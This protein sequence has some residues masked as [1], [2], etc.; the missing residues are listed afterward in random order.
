M[1]EGYI[2]LYRGI[3]DND[4]WLQEPF[5]K[6]Q[7]WIDILL[8][9]N[10]T[11]GSILLKNGEIVQIKRGDCGWSMER[12]AKRWQW[13]RGK[14]KRFFDYL[15]TQKMIQQTDIPKAT[16]INVCNYERF[17]NDTTNGHQIVHQTDTNNKGKK[18]KN[19]TTTYSDE[20]SQKIY[21]KYNNV[22]LTAEQYNRL[23]ARCTSQKL[24]DELID[25]LSANIETGKE[26][27][28]RADFPNAHSIRLERYRE[29]RVKNPQKFNA[30]LQKTEMADDRSHIFKEL[31]AEARAQ[32]R[33]IL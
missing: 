24:L 11:S 31:E 15:Q 19:T 7:A 30:K 4:L 6:G 27:P 32:G 12:L 25:S 26:Q 20:N 33:V 21:G 8:L 14:V 2:K 17:Q 18:E 5:T 29:Y 28:F 16:V 3:E 9:T 1:K 10:Y 23:L 22:C 13:S